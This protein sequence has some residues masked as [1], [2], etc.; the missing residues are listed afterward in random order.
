MAHPFPVYRIESDPPR[1]PAG[2]CPGRIGPQPRSKAGDP[3][4]QASSE[5]GPMRLRN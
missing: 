5:V 3:L 4:A 2:R 1:G